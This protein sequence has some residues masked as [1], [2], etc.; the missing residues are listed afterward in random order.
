MYSIRIKIF[1]LSTRSG[2]VG[3]NLTG[4]D[5]VIFFDS[6]WNP[7][8]DAQAQDRC[9]RIG[10]TVSSQYFRLFF[11]YNS[12]IDGEKVVKLNKMPHFFMLWKLKHHI[13]EEL[14]PTEYEHI[15]V[16]SKMRVIFFVLGSFFREE[17]Y[18]V[19]RI[20]LLE[21]YNIIYGTRG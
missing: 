4:A 18:F 14:A 9:H 16:P 7:A 10:Q 5:T 17:S 1:I 12:W 8:I 2:G 11:I 13:P 3:I 19:A 21:A 6:D 20:E 15:C